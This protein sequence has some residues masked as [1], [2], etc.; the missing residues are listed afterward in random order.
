MNTVTAPVFSLQDCKSR[1]LAYFWICDV[2]RTLFEEVFLSSDEHQAAAYSS[3][4]FKTKNGTEA[5]YLTQA[6]VWY[7]IE[8]LLSTNDSVIA[9]YSNDLQSLAE[10]FSYVFGPESKIAY[11]HNRFTR[12]LAAS[13][14]DNVREH[15]A[16][17]YLEETI[18]Y[19][20]NSK[21]TESLLSFLPDF[22]QASFRKCIWKL[23]NAKYTT[24]RMLNY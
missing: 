20:A 24:I 4:F 6:Y 15:A 21:N 1:G 17:L 18:S 12:L 2:P 13:G 7:Y 14:A 3:D 19:L 9:S 11:Y 8:Y 22:I 10:L 5:A 23:E 16:R